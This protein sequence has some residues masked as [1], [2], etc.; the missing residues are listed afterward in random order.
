MRVHGDYYP[1]VFPIEMKAELMN[2]SDCFVLDMGENI[3][4]WHGAEANMYEKNSAI[5]YAQNLK[6][7]ERMSHA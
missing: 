2:Q 3:Y 1:R 4:I 5:Y 6:N 7:H